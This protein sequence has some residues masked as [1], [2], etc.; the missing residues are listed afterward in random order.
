LATI[1]TQARN[2]H[3]AYERKVAKY[4]NSLQLYNTLTP[5]Q[6]RNPRNKPPKEPIPPDFP[7]PTISYLHEKQAEV[8]IEFA[9]K[10]YGGVYTPNAGPPVLVDLT[11]DSP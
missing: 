3:I 6:K 2:V 4:R 5:H 11:E 10:L 9:D 1:Y 7:M 8:I